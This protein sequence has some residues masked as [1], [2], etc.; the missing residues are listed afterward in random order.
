ML[1]IYDYALIGLKSKQNRAMNLI[2]PPW[3]LVD[4][5]NVLIEINESH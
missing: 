4:V 1:N 5:V 2:S 3:V